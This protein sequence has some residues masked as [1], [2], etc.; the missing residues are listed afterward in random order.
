MV[1]RFKQWLNSESGF[2]IWESSAIAVGG[3]IIAVGV[4]VIIISIVSGEYTR[5]E[6]EFIG[7]EKEADE[8]LQRF[9]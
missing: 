4:G 6:N 8:T 9:Y 3:L 7:S 1:Q 5:V 2:L